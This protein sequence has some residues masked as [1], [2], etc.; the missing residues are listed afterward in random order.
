MAD[1]KKKKLK[2]KVEYSHGG[3]TG[4][5]DVVK[6]QTK[7]G[8]MMYDAKEDRF[9]PIAGGSPFVGDKYRTELEQSGFKYQS[10][11]KYHPKKPL[12]FPKYKGDNRQS[13]LLLELGTSKLIPKGKAQEATREY[14]KSYGVSPEEIEEYEKEIKKEGLTY[15]EAFDTYLTPLSFTD[16]NSS[17]DT[18]DYLTRYQLLGEVGKPRVKNLLT[19]NKYRDEPF[20]AFYNTYNYQSPSMSI[21]NNQDLIAES[22]HAQQ[23]KEWGVNKFSERSAV[24]KRT[25]P[26]DISYD[27]W[28]YITSGTLEYDA[29][30]VREPVLKERYYSIRDSLQNRYDK[31]LQLNFK[32]GG[33]KKYKTGGI[34]KYQEG[35]FTPHKMYDQSGKEYDA[36][37]YED[38]L[39]FQKLGYVHA[40]E[41]KKGGTIKYLHGG[42]PTS[43]LRTNKPDPFFDAT[44]NSYPTSQDFYTNNPDLPELENLPNDPTQV[45]GLSEEDIAVADSRNYNNQGRF[46]ENTPFDLRAF[47]Q[48]IGDQFTP[49]NIGVGLNLISQGVRNNRQRDSERRRRA[50]NNLQPTYYTQ[51]QSYGTPLTGRGLARGGGYV[52]N[53][54]H[55]GKV[56]LSQREI[57]DLRSRG[58]EIEILG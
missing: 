5:K 57:D 39:R 16:P 17:R 22:A 15:R 31:G 45:E 6:I 37:T 12:P 23:V 7:D 36:N 58:Y 20:R 33:M 25:K 38:H 8:I 14:M 11:H 1:H 54:R 9:Y 35:G 49:Q 34:K 10:H 26:K 2:K 4:G 30:S 53:Y 42:D 50:G 21:F 46:E 18:L 32:K 3:K 52:K 13:N 29:H 47:G 43:P 24:D 41:L 48:Q 19:N 27:D 56:E 55:G 44:F 40:D 28:A 51:A